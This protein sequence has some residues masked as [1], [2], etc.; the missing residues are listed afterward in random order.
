MNQPAEK[1]SVEEQKELAARIKFK[2]DFPW[3]AAKSLWIRPKEGAL[4]PLVLN[5]AQLYLHLIAEKQRLEIGRVRIMVLKGRQQG[6]S[7]YIEGRGYWKTTHRKGYRTFILT[8]EDAATANLFEMAQ[9][10]HD[11]CLPKLKP[12]TG[13][14]SAKELS[15]PVLDSGYKVGTAG[16]KAVGRSGTAQFFHGSEVAF[17]PHA[18][19]HSM[20]VMQTIADVDETEIFLESTA[21]GMGNFFHAQWQLATK[22]ESDYIPVFLPWYW[23][24]EY[25]R[26]IDD[27][28]TLTQD[29]F[30]LITQFKKDGL[31]AEHLN[32]RR[33][34]IRGFTA[35]G[36][37]GEWK[38]K[39]EYPF[40]AAEA[41]QT[42]GEESLIDPKLV[43]GARKRELEMSGAH[44]VGVDPARFGKDRTAFIHRNGRKMYG[45]KTLRKKSTMEVAGHCVRILQDPVTGEPS[46]VQMMFI[47]II[48]LGAGVYDRL[49]ELGFGFEND[50]EGRVIGVN[51]SVS[52]IDDKRFTNKR[53]EMG[54]HMKMWFEQPGG[55]DVPDDDEFQTDMCVIQYGY[56]SSGRWKL[57]SKEHIIEVRKL[58]S[59]DYYD[60]GALTFAEPVAAP[61]L[62]KMKARASVETVNYPM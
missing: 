15:F 19:T 52:S 32:W 26:D 53:A 5:K 36:D 37:D 41:F 43:I 11:H 44:V 21:N 30:D 61:N 42:S 14:Q 47:D 20:G 54:V 4:E 27:E 24:D 12:E 31:T 40:T 3:Y 22:G 59:P 6:I 13:S 1:L 10:Y 23:Q 33:F 2:T 38:F 45:M 35:Q 57:E 25:K 18:D 16:T 29:E 17:W 8:H 50:G 34:K 62:G 55:V 46:D 9:R 58:Q 51:S 49:V 56:D 7:T 48:G 39:Q 60:A 28:F